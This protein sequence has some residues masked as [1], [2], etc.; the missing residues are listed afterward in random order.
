LQQQVD[1]PKVESL[2]DAYSLYVNSAKGTNEA[3]GFQDVNRFVQWVGKTSSI[4]QLNPQ[5]VA[6][7]AEWI[8]ARAGDASKPLEPV[9]SFLTFLKKKEY[10]DVSLSSHIRIPKSKSKLR[11]SNGNHSPERAELSAQ[12][13]KDLVSR[14]ESLKQ[15]RVKITGDIGRAMADK[16]FREN[17]PLDAA[18]ERQG[19][20]ESQIR[21]L[22]SALSTAV[23]TG[24]GPS[25]E[26]VR[27]SLGKKVVLKD[28]A[29]GRQLSYTVVHPREAN[30]AT[31]KLSSESPV[32]KAIMNRR[33]GDKVEIATPRGSMSYIIEKVQGK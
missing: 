12:G 18:K 6:S 17:A 24:A 33:Q 25:H 4:G 8:G 5:I 21:D 30:L 15:E 19:M 2:Y 26:S 16:D 11:S 31:G 10:I 20:V 23:V 9:K 3:S 1:S 14:L 28:A 13:Y 29:S 22:E 32:G 27:I 7:Y